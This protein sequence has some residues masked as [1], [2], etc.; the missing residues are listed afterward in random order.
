M[1]SQVYRYANQTY[2]EFEEHFTLELRDRG[3]FQRRRE[4]KIWNFTF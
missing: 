3:S 1:N 2:L 4:Y